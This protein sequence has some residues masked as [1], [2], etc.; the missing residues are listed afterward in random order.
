MDTVS[1]LLSINVAKIL[2]VGIQH[3]RDVD[4]GIDPLALWWEPPVGAPSGAS[5]ARPSHRVSLDG[6]CSR[7]GGLAPADS[8]LPRCGTTEQLGV[9]VSPISAR[10]RGTCGRRRR[11]R[12]WPCWLPRSPPGTDRAGVG[13]AQ[14]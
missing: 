12:E 3:G 10:L 6:F 14:I 2:R 4:M 1:Q 11:G 7:L 8:F 13:D 9:S 5:P